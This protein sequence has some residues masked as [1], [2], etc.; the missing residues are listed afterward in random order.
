MLGRRRFPVW[1][2]LWRCAVIA[3]AGVASLASGASAETLSPPKASGAT[4]NPCTVNPRLRCPDLVM[5]APSHFEFDRSTRSGHVLLRAA[6]SIDNVGSGPLEIVGRRRGSGM[7]AFQAI[8][9]RRGRRHVYRTSARLV[10]KHVPGSRYGVGSVGGA[11]YWKFHLAAAFELW[12]VDASGVATALVHKGPKLD[13]CFRDLLR[14]HPL[15]RSPGQAVYP[16]CN[17]NAGLQLDILGTSVG[18]SDIYPSEYPQQWIDVT[19]L[20]GRFAYVQIASPRHLLYE[21]DETNNLSETY[22]DLPSGRVTGHRVG[23]ER[24]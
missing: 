4:T 17:Q 22:I 11:S 15:V 23:V 20:H 21:A 7:R 6:S 10:Y 12:S 8:Y 14:T 9:D 18:W 5:S 24:P 13:Y 3:T 2:A 16:G 1:D 19:G